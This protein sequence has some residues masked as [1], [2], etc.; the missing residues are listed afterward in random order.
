MRNLTKYQTEIF[1]YAQY[2]GHVH[3]HRK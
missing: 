1:Q 2:F 3:M